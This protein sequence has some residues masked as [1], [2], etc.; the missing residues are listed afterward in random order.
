MK[1]KLM[2]VL[3]GIL[4]FCCSLLLLPQEAKADVCQGENCN[5]A[6]S[7]HVC[8]NAKCEADCGE[9]DVTCPAD[10]GARCGDGVCSSSLGENSNTC[11]ADCGTSGSCGDG[12]CSSS[13]G[14][15]SNT[16]PADCGEEAY[17]G[18]GV[19][20]SALGE[21]QN[22]CA[23]NQHYT[24]NGVS[25]WGDC[26]VMS[27]PTPTPPICDN[28]GV[29]ELGRGENNQ[30][31][32]SDCSP[33][34]GN[35][36]CNCPPENA[37]NCPSD[38]G[39]TPNC[40]DGVCQ[41][42]ETANSCPSDCQ[43]TPTPTPTPT[44]TS[45]PTP[46]PT[47]TPTPTP[48]ATPCP[49][50]TIQVGN[51]CIP[52][53]VCDDFRGTTAK[54]MCVTFNSL[55]NCKGV[56]KGVSRHAYTP[57]GK[58]FEVWCHRRGSTGLITPIFPQANVICACVRI[59]GCFHPDTNLTLSDG[60]V[61]KAKD[62]TVQDSLFN[63]VTGKSTKVLSVIESKE[64]HS[65]V[66]F[67]FDKTKVTVSQGHAVL[68][69]SGKLVKAKDLKVGDMVMGADKKFHK[70]D[71]LKQLDVVSGQKV[72]NFNLETDSRETNDHMLLSDGVVTGDL[73]VQGTLK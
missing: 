49:Y 23:A 60:S 14:E 11:P 35:G 27:T 19:C 31:C 58:D 72:I 6:S 51:Q 29:C 50:G 24:H 54:Y 13:L 56:S 64:E 3:K 41:S 15:N 59:T 21:N 52:A 43:S 63:P 45:T 26:M 10:C 34:C 9:N 38:C 40:G 28:D 5:H 67:G 68:T 44:P 48:T 25:N 17:C 62:V 22:N 65:L 36:V 12:V 37:N 33:N 57:D 1:N 18:D 30:N 4:L 53:P 47:N 32:P 55:S 70:V 42:P 8:G 66:E 69:E 2:Y 20:S 73:F 16:C 61:K 46:T 7:A 39:N 71:H